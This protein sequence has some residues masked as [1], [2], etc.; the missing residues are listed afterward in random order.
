[1]CRNARP[2]DAQGLARAA[3]GGRCTGRAAAV[4]RAARG[5][6]HAVADAV[7][8]PRTARRAVDGTA[9][10]VLARRADA[11]SAART[12]VVALLAGTSDDESTHRPHHAERFEHP[13]TVDLDRCSPCGG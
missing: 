2:R 4:I 9:R 3:V 7:A 1:K 10:V 11:I 5:R 12:A 13:S 8:T 6:L